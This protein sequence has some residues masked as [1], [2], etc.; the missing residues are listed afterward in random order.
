MMR[1]L[2]WCVRRELWEHRWTWVTPLV[3]GPVLLVVYATH[4]NPL[5]LA[6]V[7]RIFL[8]GGTTIALF[9]CAEALN[10]ERRDRSILFWR[11]LPVSDLTTVLSKAAVAMVTTPALILALIFAAQLVARTMVSAG[12]QAPSAKWLSPGALALE[13]FVTAVWQAPLYGWM[14]LVSSWARRAALLWGMVP[15]VVVPIVADT[16][17]VLPTIGN[18]ISSRGALRHL[19]RAA[20]PSGRPHPFD[21]NTVTAGDLL[22]SAELWVGV[23]VATA[24]FVAAAQVRRRRSLA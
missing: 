4:D 14:L 22:T 3:L 24:L 23:V 1:T 13:V 8:V 18:V 6:A 11:A 20:D 2:A 7:V 21:M 16:F 19:P 10:G 12:G 17:G 15:L 9:Y 5:M